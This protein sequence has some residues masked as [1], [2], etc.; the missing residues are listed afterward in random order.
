M[1]SFFEDASALAAGNAAAERYG[2]AAQ[3]SFD[4]EAAPLDDDVPESGP[5]EPLPN[6]EF[7]SMLGSLENTQTDLMEAT[8]HILQASE[9]YECQFVNALDR[10]GRSAELKL[11]NSFFHLN[12]FLKGY[13][14]HLNET[15]VEGKHLTLVAQHDEFSTSY[16]KTPTWYSNMF[17]HFFT[18]LARYAYKSNNKAKGRVA[19]ETASGY[20]SSLKA[21]Y[22]NKFR[23]SGL[24]ISVFRES[25]WR[26]LRAQLYAQYQEHKRL[27]GEK[28][29]NPHEASS[30]KDQ[31]AIATGCIWSNSATAAEF[32]HIN[33]SMTHFSG[34]CSEV[35]LNLK[36]HIRPI[37]M[38][39]LNHTYNTIEVSL[40]RHKNGV[41]QQI[42]VF[43][44]RDHW[45]QCFFFSLFYRIMMLQ[46]DGPEVFPNFHKKS[47]K[48]T[49][50]NK[51]DSRCASLWSDIFRRLMPL[52]LLV[53]QYFNKGLSSHHGKKA[54]NQKMANSYVVSGLAQI[55]RSGWIL[56]GIHSIMDYVIG[57]PV[58]SQ[59]AGKAVSNWT[60]KIGEVVVGGLPPT[61]TDIVT[62][63]KLAHLHFF[64]FPTSPLRHFLTFPSPL[65]HYF[66][67]KQI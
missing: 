62:E 54:S 28:L 36:S 24:E 9:Q 30:D 52:F 65:F 7:E 58:M 5:T 20:A 46:D 26:K 27:T 38:N 18:Y 51:N 31:R 25:I 59:Q 61:H 17:G 11:N 29:V 45:S 16:E 4:E 8:E 35:A 56:R 19:H 53:D 34:R 15:F 21:Y 64:Q 39:E 63:S 43:V 57:S 55:F 6:V 37:Q 12:I 66:P 48:Q 10:R 41:E 32:W 50:D 60:S 22:E 40:N 14:Q 42:P 47:T 49:K 23:D 44:H 67:R 3:S 33:N 2:I 13:F 1:A